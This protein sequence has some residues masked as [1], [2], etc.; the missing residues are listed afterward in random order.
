MPLTDQESRCAELLCRHL[1]GERGGRWRVAA[2]FDDEY[3][4]EPSPDML[5][6]N[7]VDEIAVE[8]KRL[9]DG[10]YLTAFFTKLHWLQD[11]LAA[12]VDGRFWL[13]PQRGVEFP[14]SGELVSR[15]IDIVPGI[16]ASLAVGESAPVPVAQRHAVLHRLRDD[17]S[18]IHCSHGA[19]AVDAEGVFYLDDDD[20]PQHR[21]VT[22]R[23]ERAFHAEL[24]RASAAA[25]LHDRAEA[26]W[27]EEW[28]LRKVADGRDGG[29]GGVAILK[30]AV[31][32]VRDAAAEAVRKA[33]M[34]ARNKFSG[35]K[36]APGAAVALHVGEAGWVLDAEAFDDAVSDF[37]A[38]DVGLL[39]VVFVVAADHVHAFRFHDTAEA[40]G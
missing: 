9:T 33:V 34:D 22:D 19:I 24:R 1:G 25:R 4:S 21:P 37:P 27:C 2:L 5:L 32:D 17:G 26:S 15:L 30:G 14:L 23:S 3:P 11:R 8:I 35:R 36:W 20:L 40:A 31:G 38:S 7:G 6:S 18:A 39:D 28:E 12:G 13:I 29:A 10:E 16:A